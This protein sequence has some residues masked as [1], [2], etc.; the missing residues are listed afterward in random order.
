MYLRPLNYALKM[1]EMVN[2]MLC[3]F[4]QQ[5][6]HSRK[7]EW[8]GVE[9]AEKKCNASLV[10]CAIYSLPLK[11]PDFTE[12]FRGQTMM[13]LFVYGIYLQLVI[14]RLPAAVIKVYFTMVG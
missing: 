10:Y 13:G 4:L 8:S 2:F 7:K 12:T 6:N 5:Q 11:Y 1:V 14:I 9:E 3:I